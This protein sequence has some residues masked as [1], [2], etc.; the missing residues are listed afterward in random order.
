M[1]LRTELE[2]SQMRGQDSY[3]FFIGAGKETLFLQLLTATAQWKEL[4]RPST[5]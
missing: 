5:R 3:I 2:M 1:A 4:V